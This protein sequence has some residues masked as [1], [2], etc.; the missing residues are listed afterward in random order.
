VEWIV[1]ESRIEGHRLRCAC[2]AS[3]S[4]PCWRRATLKRPHDFG[5]TGHGHGDVC[6]RRTGPR[7]RDFPVKADVAPNISTS[8]P[9]GTGLQDPL[10][11]RSG[12]TKQVSPT[13]FRPLQ[14]L[15]GASLTK[16]ALARRRTAPRV[17][18]TL[19]GDLPRQQVLGTC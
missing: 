4:T 14:W 8:L 16:R 6:R 5:D 13:H 18:C 12:C 10:E 7:R 11:Q 19:D 9:P 17:A 15:R 3:A 1:R 2:S